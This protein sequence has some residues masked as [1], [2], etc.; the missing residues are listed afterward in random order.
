NF[1]GL[2][3]NIGSYT[4]SVIENAIGGSGNDTTTGNSADNTLTGNGGNDTL[5]GG[6]G[7]DTIDGGT[8]TDTAVYSGNHTQYVITLNTNGS[9]SLSDQRSGSPDGLDIISNVE[10]F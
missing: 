1:G 4:T 5:T 10:S 9:Y 7:N 8:G 2:V 6:T 3:G